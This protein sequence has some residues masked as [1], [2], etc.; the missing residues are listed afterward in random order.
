MLEE[1]A[2]SERAMLN[3]DLEYRRAMA[4]YDAFVASTKDE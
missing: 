1:A 3:Y 2:V 4:R